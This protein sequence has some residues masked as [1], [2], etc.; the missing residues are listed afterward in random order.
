MP[1]QLRKEKPGYKCRDKGAIGG[2]W[3]RGSVRWRFGDADGLNA[4]GIPETIQ[5]WPQIIVL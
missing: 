3:V 2:Q 4:S 5:V 1:G